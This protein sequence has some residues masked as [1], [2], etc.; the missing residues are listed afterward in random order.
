MLPLPEFIV[1]NSARSSGQMICRKTADITEEER[2]VHWYVVRAVTDTNQPVQLEDIASALKLPLVRVQE[3]IQKL[4]SLKVFFYRYNSRGINWA[5]P[6]TSDPNRYH[7]TFSTG[8][9]CTAA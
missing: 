6:V 7:L 8:E 2:Q 9:E 5:Y 1:K 3:I 4:E